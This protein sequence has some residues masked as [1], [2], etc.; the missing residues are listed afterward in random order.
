MVARGCAA[1]NLLLDTPASARLQSVCVVACGREVIGAS[2]YTERVLLAAGARRT[3]YF[4]M[5]CFGTDSRA[6][7][8]LW[9][10]GAHS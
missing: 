2:A 5:P 7:R 3:I 9:L 4:S 10:A 8:V 6:D 1:L